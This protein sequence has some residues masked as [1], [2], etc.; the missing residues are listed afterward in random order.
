MKKATVRQIV[1]SFAKLN[2]SLRAGE[3]V[4]ITAH[5]KSIGQYTKVLARRVKMPNFYKACQLGYGPAVGDELAKR[6]LAD[7][8]TDETLP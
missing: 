1:H 5:G 8:Q 3:T 4:E 6:I 2:Q 7:V